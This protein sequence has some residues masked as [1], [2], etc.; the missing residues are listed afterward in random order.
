MAYVSI[1]EFANIPSTPGTLINQAMPVGMFDGNAVF[2]P[3]I[4]LTT[5][6]TTS[7]AF[8]ANTRY[9]RVNANGIC[10][11]LIGPAGQTT[12]S[13]ASARLAA[14]VTEYFGV[15]PGQVFSCITGS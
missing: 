15:A 3:Q 1:I 2:Q 4:T 5:A 9:I 13:T 7:A 10:N 8:G 11:F 14:N 12:A 6:S